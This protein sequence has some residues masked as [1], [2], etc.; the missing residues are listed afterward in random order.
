MCVEHISAFR[1]IFAKVDPKRYAHTVT[2][3]RNTLGNDLAAIASVDLEKWATDC[4]AGPVSERVACAKCHE[5]AVRMYAILSLPEEVT[6]PWSQGTVAPG[7]RI[8]ENVLHIYRDTLLS[9]L[10]QTWPLLTC[11][12]DIEWQLIVAGV[13]VA[14]GAAEDRHF[15]EDCL[16][17]IWKSPGNTSA[18]FIKHIMKVTDFWSSGQPGWE[19]CFRD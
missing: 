6:T 11:K 19:N 13:A 5:V 16:W 17:T 2:Q 3:A 10:R 4:D 1:R 7:L 9:M 15:V 14:D 12:A 18:D 8:F